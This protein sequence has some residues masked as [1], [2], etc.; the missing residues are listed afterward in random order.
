MSETN[1][2]NASPA[3]GFTSTGPERLRFGPYTGEV[4]FRRRTDGVWVACVRVQTPDGPLEVC[5]HASEDEVART[6]VHRYRAAASAGFDFGT[7]FQDFTRDVSI[8]TRRLARNRAVNRTI[9]DVRRVLDMPALNALSAIPYVGPVFGAARAAAQLADQVA[10]GDRGAT[11][12]L[13]RIHSA[14]RQGNPVA[15]Q[16][17]TAIN[18]VLQPN[19]GAAP[20]ARSRA[21]RRAPRRIVVSPIDSD[22]GGA[23]LAR[24]TT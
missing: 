22:E 1:A 17:I 2:T 24:R 15:R 13:R 6:L 11:R 23:P 21:P 8:G 12:N 10:N 4:I 7:L 3:E 5:G 16:A 9:G 19:D 14:A 18:S 20:R